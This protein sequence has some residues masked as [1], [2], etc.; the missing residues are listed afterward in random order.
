MKVN[1]SEKEIRP[2]G[3]LAHE[4]RSNAAELMRWLLTRSPVCGSKMSYWQLI[5]LRSKANGCGYHDKDLPQNNWAW[6]KDTWFQQR[7]SR[8]FKDLDHTVSEA[9]TESG[10]L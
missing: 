9:S 3:F 5:L 2:P 10:A 7:L 1:H 6:P 8:H 4:S